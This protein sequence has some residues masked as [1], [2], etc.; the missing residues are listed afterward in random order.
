MLLDPQEAFYIRPS[1]P[2]DIA[3]LDNTQKQGFRQ[4]EETKEHVPNKRTG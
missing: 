4:N 3:E 2:G 1:R